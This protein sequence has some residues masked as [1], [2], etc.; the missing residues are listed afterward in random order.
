MSIPAENIW[1]AGAKHNFQSGIFVYN[2]KQKL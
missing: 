2:M 1:Q